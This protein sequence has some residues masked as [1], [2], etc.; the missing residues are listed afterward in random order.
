MYQYPQVKFQEYLR[1]WH[2]ASGQNRSFHWTWIS[3]YVFASFVLPFD[4]SVQ[5]RE[6]RTWSIKYKPGD[7]Y[8]EKR[9]KF[10]KFYLSLT[11]ASFLKRTQKTHYENI[12]T[13]LTTA[14][15][16]RLRIW[17]ARVNS[18][19]CRVNSAKFVS[20]VSHELFAF[21]V[22]ISVGFRLW[23]GDDLPKCFC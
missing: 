15:P 8:L 9:F 22:N 4:N 23:H 13:E 11:S 2:L 20:C 12:I 1:T 21:G 16:E 10:Y 5:L 6:Q 14:I 7:L 19:A 3:L 18:V 17:I